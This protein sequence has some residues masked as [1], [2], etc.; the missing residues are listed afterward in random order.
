ML[1]SP[2]PVDNMLV[3]NGTIAWHPVLLLQLPQEALTQTTSQLSP[4]MWGY[5]KYFLFSI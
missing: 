4:T 2:V 5:Q 1:T 3:Q